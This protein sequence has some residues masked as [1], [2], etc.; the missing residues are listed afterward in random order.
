M[1]KC[2][3]SIVTR[4]LKTTNKRSPY[5]DD[6]R[7]IEA[8]ATHTYETVG[9]NERCNATSSDRQVVSR[10][11]RNAQGEQVFLIGKE[12]SY[13]RSHSTSHLQVSYTSINPPTPPSYPQISYSALKRF[14]NPFFLSLSL[15]LPSLSL[16]SPPAVSPPPSSLFLGEA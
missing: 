5:T 16:P 8:G 6:D 12:L 2:T 4:S 15:S 3:A 14:H 1:P 7:S 11:V 10:E 9:R 13:I